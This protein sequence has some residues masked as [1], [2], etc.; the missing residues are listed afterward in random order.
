MRAI[1]RIEYLWKCYDG[2]DCGDA[3]ALRGMDLEVAA[4]ETVS[5]VATAPASVARVKMLRVI[6]CSFREVGWALT[7]PSP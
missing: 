2:E 4:R 7:R 5:A 1:I 6:A 3:S